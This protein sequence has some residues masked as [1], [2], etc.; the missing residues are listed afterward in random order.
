MR[1]AST[2]ALTTLFVLM[3]GGRSA[4]ALATT[5]TGCTD[6]VTSVTTTTEQHDD[7]GSQVRTTVATTT[8]TICPETLS[9]SPSSARPL[10]TVTVTLAGAQPQICTT[11][12][13]TVTTH[14]LVPI[15]DANGTLVGYT[16]VPTTDTFS[17][18]TCTVNTAAIAFDG[19]VVGTATATATGLVGTFAVP[20]ASPGAHTITATPAAGTVATA[21]FTVLDTIAPF[22]TGTR[23]PA[24]NAAGWNSSDVIV[25]F[26]CFDA[27]SGMQS[28]TA[29]TTL[30]A[31]GAGQSVTG[32]AVD[33]AGNT[34][35]YTVSGINIDRTSPTIEPHAGR[36][37]DHGVWYTAPVTITFDCAD[38]LSGIAF[39]SGP[40]TLSTDGRGV[41]YTA[42]A[43]D[44]AGNGLQFANN[45]NIDQTPPT[46]TAPPAV[47][48]ST[49]LGTCAA[50]PALGSPVA[51]D[52]LGVVTVTSDAPPSFARGTRTVIWTATDPAGHSA[53]AQQL[54]TVNDLE[55]PTVHAPLT[56]TAIATSA[57][58]TVI[59]T[60]SLGS[61]TATDNCAGV[62]VASVS[63]IPAGNLFPIGTTTLTWTATDSSGNTGSATQTVTVSFGLCLLYD[64][65]K[66]A[67]SGSTM[68]IKVQLCTAG[69]ANQ[70]SAG[71]L[72]RAADAL[73]A[74]SATPV[75]VSASGNANPNGV[76]RY[77]ATLGGTGGYIYN[78]DTAGLAS[79]LWQLRFTVN[80]QTYS[81]PFQVK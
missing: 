33:N 20:S 71:L 63:G 79:G 66:A 15:Y 22:I 31:E 30:S 67:Q 21:D 45:L 75:P 80:G 3:I 10:A 57:S 61:A 56:L 58:G 49:S 72:P 18:V 32:T 50:S 52:N 69:G 8:I 36:A 28:C 81:A 38:A 60:G 48:A 29:D 27:D 14:H 54:V 19:L 39:C 78:L 16:D 44:N 42:D 34:A 53:S 76:F 2:L 24:A 9:A 5:P 23:V 59:P 64:P 51:A 35:T 55:R 43:F 74:G 62:S 47:I 77:D 6:Q 37:P 73:R 70:S 11:F 17:S 12:V 41:L 25:E 68:P 7:S 46:I 26:V 4:P 1:R 13:T 40:V 65:A